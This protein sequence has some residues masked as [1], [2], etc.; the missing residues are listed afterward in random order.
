MIKNIFDVFQ[1]FG[2]FI[3]TEIA[4]F[5]EGKKIVLGQIGNKSIERA[6]FSTIWKK[7]IDLRPKSPLTSNKK[8]MGQQMSTTKSKNFP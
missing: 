3:E 5:E 7:R 6:L 8:L 1:P 4:T 2:Y